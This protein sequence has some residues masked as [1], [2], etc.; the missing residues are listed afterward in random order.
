[1]H[2]KHKPDN[3]NQLNQ[4]NDTS[5]HKRLSLQIPIDICYYISNLSQPQCRCKVSS[6]SDECLTQCLLLSLDVESM[7]SHRSP[8]DLIPF[9]SVENR[10]RF[11]FDVES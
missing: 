6:I 5:P 1:M 10:T 8:R 7:L 3:T 2:T 4:D 9:Q 11:S